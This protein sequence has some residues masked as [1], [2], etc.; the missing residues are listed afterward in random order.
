MPE[1][2]SELKYP[3]LV[4]Q[5]RGGYELRIPELL[6]VVRS[7]TLQA[8]LDELHV[9]IGKMFDGARALDALD[10]IPAPRPPVPL[11]AAS[12]RPARR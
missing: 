9:R 5:R 3:V 6:I 2:R 1:A 11:R 7:E 8:G 12:S 10:E 4:T